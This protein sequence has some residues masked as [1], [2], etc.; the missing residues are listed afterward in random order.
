MAR[1]EIIEAGGL[2]RF[3]P[4][5][6]SETED[7]VPTFERLIGTLGSGWK[8]DFKAEI[9]T[10]TTE[11]QFNHKYNLQRQARRNISVTY[12]FPT[13]PNHRSMI[14]RFLET[15][16]KLYMVQYEDSRP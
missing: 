7:D 8:E 15:S 14:L 11:L 9:D 1:D 13:S 6:E 2:V 5:R 3:D 10:Y 16:H 4:I 12:D